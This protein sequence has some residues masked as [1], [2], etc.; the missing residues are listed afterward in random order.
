MTERLSALLREEAE[1]LQPP[2]PPTRETLAAGRRITRGRRLASS[3]AVAAA[4]VVVGVGAAMV[5]Q[6]SDARDDAAITEPASTGKPVDLGVVFAE[7]NRVYLNGGSSSVLLDEVAQAL[8][9]TSAGL[10]VR[11]NETGASDGGAPFHFVLIGA[12]GKASTLGVTLGEVVPSTDPSQPLLAYARSDADEVQVVVHD[13]STDTEVTR[14]D[15]PGLDW[16]GGWEAP[17]VSIAGDLVYV[18]GGEAT[19]VVNWRTRKVSAANSVDPVWPQAGGRSMVL[20]EDGTRDGVDIASG[21]VLVS[22]AGLKF[23]WGSNSPDGRFAI[24]Y[25]QDSI[26]GAFEV[27]TLDRGTKVSINEPAWEF[28]WT[29]AG[30]LYRVNKAGV[31]Q[32]DVETGRCTTTPLPKGTSVGD[33]VVL[34]GKTYES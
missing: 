7:G 23:P 14:V 28:G 4:V 26:K 34:G 32:C 19:T 6:G 3:V 1:R 24:I 22:R 25:D 20:R 10:L 9:Y 21:K 18:G 15:V 17:P 12:D 16:S 31:H 8:Y 29:A 5:G 2:P 27:Y 33:S 13:L 11:T 30:G